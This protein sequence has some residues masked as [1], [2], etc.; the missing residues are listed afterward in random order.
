M[1]KK[2][3]RLK[4]GNATELLGMPPN[5]HWVLLANY[6]DKTLL[7]NDITFDLG[8]RMAFAYTPRS[9][10]VHVV[11]NGSYEG[12]YQLAEQVR[13][14]PD[15]VNI[16]ELEAGD[17]SAATITGGYLL[18][19]DETRGDVFC[20]DGTRSTM[21]FC[22]RNPETL[23]EPGWEKQRA[24]I[25]GYIRQVEEVLFGPTF[26]D[27]TA[28]YP[29]VIDVASAVDYYLVNEI[30]R[31]VD[32]NLRR[33][34]YLHKPRG[35]KLTFGPIWDF[36]LAMGNANYDGADRTEGWHLRSTAWYGRLFQDPAFANRVKGRWQ[37]LRGSGT[38]TEWQRHIL[39][40]WD[41]LI[42]A[43]QQ[44]FQRWPILGTWVW[45]NRVVMGSYDGEVAA[46]R[47]WLDARIRWMD[48]ELSR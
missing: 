14:G 28:G 47:A 18:E 36:D 9:E 13:L 25:T 7:R 45:P 35:G 23:L 38:L 26:T 5:R 30:V 42:V 32:G 11:L 22:A 20:F 41:Y 46:M 44:N 43:Q 3:Y 39:A 24:Y 31:N 29:S 8:R 15:R 10:Y 21:V 19:V 12:L 17:T 40:R 37:E 34:T 2:P 16:P 4:L 27:V 33:S 1:P 48:G 6:A